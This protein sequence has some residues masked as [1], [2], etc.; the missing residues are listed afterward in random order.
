MDQSF[1]PNEQHAGE[2]A[3]ASEQIS[4]EKITQRFTNALEGNR[5]IET[6]KRYFLH[7]EVVSEKDFSRIQ[8]LFEVRE[9]TS[10]LADI[11]QYVRE[12][13]LLSF[14][15]SQALTHYLPNNYELVVDMIFRQKIPIELFAREFLK[16][17]HE[18]ESV[19]SGASTV[20]R[21]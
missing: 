2:T 19:L 9:E 4:K 6:F 13:G 5:Y 7:H 17:V 8:K 12:H 21:S 15:D 20:A 11:E 1:S 14:D 3:Q 10:V 16:Q 18:R